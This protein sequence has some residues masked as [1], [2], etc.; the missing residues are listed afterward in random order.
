MTQNGFDNIRIKVKVCVKENWGSPF[1]VGFML[2]LIVAA[3]S[4]SVGWSSI[5]DTAAVYA[6]YALVAGVFL[7]LACFLKYRGKSDGD[8]VAV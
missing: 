5:A 4:L 1:I 2:F 6:Y 7:Q 8:E 3:G